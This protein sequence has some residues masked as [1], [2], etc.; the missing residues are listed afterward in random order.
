MENEILEKENQEVEE[1]T[2]EEVV[3][4]ELQ[5][6]TNEVEETNETESSENIST[7]KSFEFAINF[8]KA[9]FCSLVGSCI[10]SKKLFEHLILPN[11]INWDN[12]F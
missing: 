3:A 2:N 11:A 10:K 5:E 9:Y 7:D 6:E 1:S 8:L 4:D 12:L